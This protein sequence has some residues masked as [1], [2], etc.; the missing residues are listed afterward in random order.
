ME[1]KGRK[2]M[3][4]VL[5]ADYAGAT[6]RFMRGRPFAPS[7]DPELIEDRGQRSRHAAR[8]GNLR[9]RACGGLRLKPALREIEAPI[10]AINADE[11][12]TNLEAARRSAPQFD[13]VIIEPVGH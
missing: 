2:A 9:H 11:Y 7:T 12:P 6:G 3:L 4:A 10:H 8:W 1:P 13:A 5:R